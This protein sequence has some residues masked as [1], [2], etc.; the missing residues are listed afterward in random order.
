[1]LSTSAYGEEYIQALKSI[2]HVD[3]LIVYSRG[4]RTERYET[5]K[6]LS[7]E[8]NPSHL[9]KIATF[10]LKLP[11][12]EAIAL[13]SLEPS[14]PSFYSD[15]FLLDAMLS[16]ANPADAGEA[17]FSMALQP[18]YKQGLEGEDKELIGAEALMRLSVKGAPIYPSSFIPV[19]ERGHLIASV[20]ALIL[21]LALNALS[22]NDWIPRISVNVS[23]IELLSPSYAQDVLELISASG[24]SPE[25]IELEVTE[26]S[27][28]ND[29][30]SEAHLH[31]LS[32][33][34]VH[35]SIDDFGTGVTKFDYLAKL[36]VDVIKID[37]SLVL[38]H[39]NAPESYG[40]LLKAISAVGSACEIDVIA[41]GVDAEEQVLGLR[42][43]GIKY[44]QGYY[45]GK[46]V[47]L[48]DF[49]HD[50]GPKI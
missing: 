20:D 18:K 45:Y 21:K 39:A 13:R 31:K 32:K 23:A 11:Q 5:Y 37:R 2:E 7:E 6:R 46:P 27:V 10:A 8:E 4:S 19:A 9:D 43:L 41:E 35:I 42:K 26:G 50:H 38:A 29:M 47:P 34:G 33:A 16:A 1:M 3:T 40:V 28:I 17:V 24:V 25:R 48:S 14:N 44:F 36:P 30:S 12:I 49:I 22:D 15:E